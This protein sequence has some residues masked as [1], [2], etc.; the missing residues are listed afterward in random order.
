[1]P[2]STPNILAAVDLGSNSFHLHIARVVDDQLYP[3][4]SHKETVRLG[5]GVTAQKAFDAKTTAR[6]LDALKLFAE[7]LRGMRPDAVRAVGTN[8]LRVAKN[9][10]DF[11]HEAEAALG[12]PIEIISGREEAR[13]IYIGVAHSIPVS[14]HNRLVID[15]G[16]GSTEF[17][18]GY[19]MK[20]K[21]TESLYVGCVTFSQRFF[22]EG[23]TDKKN[24]RQAELA[25]RREIETITA[26]FGKAGWKETVGSSGTAKALAGI[27]QEN[28]QGDGGITLPGLEWL[29]SQAIKVGSFADLDLPG[30][31]A[32]RVPV[33]PGGLAVM[34]AAFEELGLKGM[35]VSDGALRQGVLYDLLGRSH[36]DDVRDSTIEQIA[37]RYHTDN[38]QSERVETMALRF[39]KQIET[40]FDPGEDEGDYRL[41]RAL[42]W[43]CRLHEIG[44][45]IAQSAFHKHS[46]YILANA[47][48]PGFSKQEQTWLAQLVLAQRGK[49]DKVAAALDSDPGLRLLAFCLRLAVLLYRSRRALDTKE[50]TVARKLDGFK[51]VVKQGWLTEHSLTEYGL[52]AEANEWEKL[53]INFEIAER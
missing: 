9:A 24:F 18:I 34:I 36:H 14:S 23:K 11:L 32:E 13:L 46:A 50:F 27:L 44:I 52:K 42:K 15:I 49:L 2:S 6:A 26:R 19:R 10:Q 17:I 41:M 35:T 31:R 25:A 39:L 45:S 7:R 20:P 1:M 28:R 22:S 48:M 12:F 47:D 53:G 21:V 8:A 40:D 37:K 5:A 30:L 38:V 33:L 43:A 29:K 4:D 51:L 3:L 16:G